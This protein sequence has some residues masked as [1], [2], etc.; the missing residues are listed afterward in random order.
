MPTRLG[1]RGVEGCSERPFP[2]GQLGEP[3][4][5]SACDRCEQLARADRRTSGSRRYCDGCAVDVRAARARR[6]AP[7]RAVR[8]RRGM[9]ACERLGQPDAIGVGVDGQ[10]GRCRHGRRAVHRAGDR[11]VAA[12]ARDAAGLA[13]IRRAR[14]C[15][16]AQIERDG[17]ERDRSSASSTG[18]SGILSSRS[19][20]VD[21]GAEARDGGSE[22]AA[23]LLRTP[24]RRACR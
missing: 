17:V 6:I 2:A 3:G 21:N 13:A 22:T 20:M 15:G 16:A 18:S 11:S 7:C 24:A 23:R 19:I 8:C 12:A 4:L 14:S 1:V 5:R 10:P 9:L